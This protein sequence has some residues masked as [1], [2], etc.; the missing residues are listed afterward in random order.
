MTDTARSLQPEALKRYCDPDTFD[1]ETT[2]DLALL[3]DFIGQARAMRAVDFGAGIASHGFNVYALGLPGSGR[4]T[5]TRKFLEQIAEG[6]P[7]PD[8]WCYVNSFD[9]PQKPK[10]L[11]LPAGQGTTLRDNMAELIEHCRQDI[12]KAF[13]SEEYQQERQKVTDAYQ[14]KQEKELEA[15]RERLEKDSFA[16]LRV[17]GGLMLTPAVEGRPLKERDLEK[18]SEEEREKV[19][20][21]RNRL[22]KEVERGL[23]QLRQVE[24]TMR[25]E[26]K[27][28]DEETT[29]RAIGHLVDDLREQY[30]ATPQV[31]DYLDNVQADI[32]ATIDDFRDEKEGDRPALVGAPFPSQTP[33]LNRYE[34][35]VLVDRS[36]TKGAPV[37]VE[38]NPTYHNLIGRIEH[39]AFMGAVATDFTMLK[40]GA[41]HRANGGYL[42]LP[43][44]EVLINYLAWDALK[45]SLKDS[46]VR[47]EELG[48]QLSLISTVTLEPESVPLDVK[49]VLIGNPL[50]YY[51]LHAYDEDFQKLFKVKADFATVM[52]RN[53]ETEKQYALFVHTI[54]KENKLRPF[55]RSAVARLIEHSSR[56]VGN[57]NKLSTRFGEVADLLKEA[58]FWAGRRLSDGRHRE[59]MSTDAD[60]GDPENRPDSRAGAPERVTSLDVKQA[61]NEKIFRSNLIEERIHE[62][63][64]EGTL[65]IDTSDTV[66]GQVNGLSV[67][68]VGDYLFARPSRVTAS[69]YTG[70]TG[71]VNIERE[72][73]LSGPI[74]SKGV[75]I[76][77]SYLGHKYAQ[78]EP[79]ALSASLVFEQ[80][81]SGVEGDS[82]SSTELYALLSSLSGYPIKQG[83]AVTGSVDQHGRVQPIGGVNEKIEGFFD[84]CRAKGLTGE[85][86]V[87]VPA[88]NERHLML[89]QDVIDAVGE[90]RFHIWAVKTIDEGIALLTGHEAG[91]QDED[92]VYSQ[93]SVNWAVADRLA[94][95][96]AAIKTEAEEEESDEGS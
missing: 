91:E 13:Q 9:D 26:L 77:A 34:V 44:R 30:S 52:D 96:A 61:I 84:V 82:A 2:D 81:Y 85:Q 40:P 93:G 69:T 6:E 16:L 43:V 68:S 47:I 62:I 65:R 8:D 79:L 7:T 89:R 33:S 76:L 4:T 67:L 15:L 51:L 66:I 71:V 94:E 74:H 88:A 50:I 25:Q 72:V 90:G 54:C 32:V 42:V 28:L 45:R 11:R 27:Q 39:H 87:I 63:I 14:K 35:N 21:L 73:E 38:T 64:S 41:L 49:I 37:I 60:G 36:D 78:K 3:E 20:K 95:M 57:Q 56:M 24:E 75:L 19:Q 92:G 31:V 53:A 23:R 58:N 46:C 86:G 12:P 70:K 55:D 17:P 5:L 48:A 83:I 29:L 1:F 59:A 22:E 18:L 80:S 10:T